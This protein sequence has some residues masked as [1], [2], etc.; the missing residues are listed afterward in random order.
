MPRVPPFGREIGRV[1]QTRRLGILA[2]LMPILCAAD[3]PPVSKYSCRGWE[4]VESANFRVFQVGSPLSD[5]RMQEI[6]QYR[7]RTQEKWVSSSLRRS[8][9]PK[10]DVYVYPTPAS[11]EKQTRQSAEMLALTSLE[12]GEGRVWRRGVSIRGDLDREFSAVLKH[13]ITHV[14]LADVFSDYPIPAWLD[15]GI[16]VAEER[17]E[18]RQTLHGQ[19]LDALEVKRHEKLDRLFGL[20]QFPPDQDRADLIYAQSASLVEYLLT[21]KD[22][23]AVIQFAKA[24]RSETTTS[25]LRRHFGFQTVEEAENAWVEWTRPTSAG[26][27]AQDP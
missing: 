21:L 26:P 15:E 13:E 10:C 27:L 11:F 7:A 17:S 25:A 23:Q 12:V 1:I 22:P 16:A 19:L 6:E 14:L 2:L 3:P 20:T 4:V 8:W 18:R 24:C 9:S 5:E